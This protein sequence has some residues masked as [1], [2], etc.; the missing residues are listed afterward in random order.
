[1]PSSNQS[2]APGRASHSSVGWVERSD[3]HR[4][5]R[6]ITAWVSLCSTHPTNTSRTC[7]S[8]LGR[9]T[10]VLR[11]CSQQIARTTGSPVQSGGRVE[12]LY[13]TTRTKND[14]PGL[15]HRDNPRS[16]ARPL[17]ALHA[18]CCP[19]AGLDQALL[20]RLF[21]VA[22]RQLGHQRIVRVL[23]RQGEDNAW[24][25]RSSSLATLLLLVP[26]VSLIRYSVCTLVSLGKW[27]D[28]GC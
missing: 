11:S 12:V 1:M 6:H 2:I 4:A 26:R 7:R 27:R 3:T 5:D 24:V 23:E 22:L 9:D 8:G 21:Q 19:Y 20:R 13:I 17:A 14:G 28:N 18:S 25:S 10:F 15:A 16:S